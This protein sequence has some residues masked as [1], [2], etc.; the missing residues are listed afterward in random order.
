MT[1]LK[2]F[3]TIAY[4]GHID[5]PD[6]VIDSYKQERYHACSPE[7]YY[8]SNGKMTSPGKHKDKNYIPLIS[9]ID[10][11]VE[12]YLDYVKIN[13]KLKC[14]GAW[15]NLHTEKDFVQQ[16]FHPNAMVSGIVYID[17]PDGSAP[18]KFHA[19]P[20]MN[21]MF[22]PF[23]GHDMS[24]LAEISFPVETGDILL[25]PSTIL[26]SVPPNTKPINR[27]S[28]AFDYMVDGTI[29]TYVNKTKI[30]V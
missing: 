24:K 7:N 21:H 1:I 18:L 2:M 16:H 27:Y 20:S 8:T 14:C 10:E 11:H 26:H 3:P 12:K 22:G 6:S 25:Y 9:L 23:F 28:F 15:I 13:K 5:I 17:A 4:K 30:L 19:N 29:D